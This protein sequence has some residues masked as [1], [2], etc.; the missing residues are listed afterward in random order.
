M[1]SSITIRTFRNL[2]SR[3]SHGRYFNPLTKKNAFQITSTQIDAFSSKSM[4]VAILGAASKTGNLGY[5]P[6][7]F[8]LYILHTDYVV[9]L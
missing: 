6:F 2:T 7:L 3:I 5:I 1:F 9:T 8:L 4:K